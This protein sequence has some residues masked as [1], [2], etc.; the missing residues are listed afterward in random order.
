MNFIDTS[1]GEFS[2]CPSIQVSMKVITMKHGSRSE[3]PGL[4]QCSCSQARHPYQSV[5]FEPHK[6]MRLNQLP[7]STWSSLVTRLAPSV[8]ET[9]EYEHEGSVQKESSQNDQID[10]ILA[11]DLH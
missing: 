2:L 4:P 1:F 5:T 6:P 8:A 7:L 11:R 3:T 10:A 9:K